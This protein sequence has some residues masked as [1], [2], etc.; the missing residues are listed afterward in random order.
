MRKPI[1]ALLA[2]LALAATAFAAPPD[3]TAT[4][5]A[6]KE[7]DLTVTVAADPNMAQPLSYQWKKDGVAIAPPK[8]TAEPFI[9]LNVQPSD[10]G[11]Y[12]VTVSNSQGSTDSLNGAVLTVNPAPTPPSGAVVQPPSVK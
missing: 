12:T 7:V 9:L 4:I 11:R 8:G 3:T 5:V 1:L 10:S 2:A 6:G